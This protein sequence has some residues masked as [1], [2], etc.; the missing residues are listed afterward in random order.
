MD[1]VPEVIA[2]L[3]KHTEMERE[4]TNDRNSAVSAERD[5]E[6]MLRRLAAHPLGLSPVL[7]TARAPRRTPDAVTEQQVADWRST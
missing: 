1:N 2:L 3:R 7:Q 5:L 6:V 4:L